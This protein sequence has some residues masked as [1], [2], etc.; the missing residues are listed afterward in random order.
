MKEENFERQK[1]SVTPPAP[2]P[3][4]VTPP[5]AKTSHPD[6]TVKPSHPNPT[7]EEAKHGVVAKEKQA[8]PAKAAKAAPEGPHQI[9][10]PGQVPG[11]EVWS[12][13]KTPTQAP[14]R[15]GD[16]TDI[17]ILAQPMDAEYNTYVA[18]QNASKVPIVVGNKLK[19]DNE[20]MLVTD[21]SDQNNLVVSR[22]TPAETHA[23][24]AVVY[25]S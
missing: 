5:P 24:G 20:F 13:P 7:P 9:R 25:I 17:G 6:P 18:L 21:A 11:T 3:P 16:L 8:P 23:T 14:T 2:K 22:G 15:V 4:I 1:P 12:G 19:I 10:I